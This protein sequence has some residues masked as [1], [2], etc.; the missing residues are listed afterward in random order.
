[1]R[2]IVSMTIIASAML[3][4]FAVAASASYSNLPLM[5]KDDFLVVDPPTVLPVGVY[6]TFQCDGD[7]A[8]PK[9]DPI[10]VFD[11]VHAS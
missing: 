6:G 5:T 10:T 4:A 2:R 9:G 7:D 8:D 3:L 11:G 1:M